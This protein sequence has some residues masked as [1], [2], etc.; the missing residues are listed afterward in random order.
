MIDFGQIFSN[1]FASLW[2]VLPFVIL[3]LLFKSAWF[4][5]LIGEAMVNMAA[6]LFLNK[7]DYHLIKNVTLAT[8]DGTTQIDHIIVSHFGVFVVETK[9]I[10]GWIF[11]GERQKLW[12]QQ[13]FKSKHKFQNPLHQN[14]KHTKTLESI[15]G[16]ESDKLFS[17]VVFVGDSTFKTEMPEN[18]TY[19]AGYISFIKSK[20]KALL[21]KKEVQ[22]CIHQIVN[23]RLKPSIKTNIQHIKHV[24]EIK[25]AK[26]KAEKPLNTK[27]CSKCGSQMVL[28]T[29]KKGSEAGSQFWGC[30][31][32]PKCRVIKAME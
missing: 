29:A 15:L 26:N 31:T 32:F 6:K 1:A 25:E 11:G 7:N 4:K 30:S 10:K 19:A 9:N 12:T 3:A 18:V 13:I 21:T 2:W 14:Y 20:T 22:K 24:R 8:E 5:G 17:V 27:S 23:G 28:R 16:I